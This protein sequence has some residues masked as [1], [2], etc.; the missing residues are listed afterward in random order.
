MRRS[1]LS[2]TAV[3]RQSATRWF[4]WCAGRT[5][6]GPSPIATPISTPCRSHPTRATRA[7]ERVCSSSSTQSS[8]VGGSRMWCWRSWSATP[9][10]SA[11]MRAGGFDRRRPFS[12]DSELSKS[13]HPCQFSGSRARVA[14]LTDGDHRRKVVAEDARDLGFRYGRQHNRGSLVVDGRQFVAQFH[15]VIQETRVVRAEEKLLEGHERGLATREHE[16]EV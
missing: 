1:S 14:R 6:R 8:P 4:I 16:E 3:P 7:L 11:S 5:T 9:T 10:P 12:T 2:R 13:A 15:G